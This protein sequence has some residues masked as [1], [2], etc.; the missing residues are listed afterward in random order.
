MWD[1]PRAPRGL[2]RAGR[3][4]PPCSPHPP[5]PVPTSGLFACPP[6]G[7]APA[8]LSVCDNRA[9]NPA[10]SANYSNQHRGKGGGGGSGTH[11]GLYPVSEVPIMPLHST[12]PLQVERACGEAGGRQ[13]EPEHF[14]VTLAVTEGG[15][16]GHP[17]SRRPRSPL[18]P[19]QGSSSLLSLRIRTRWLLSSCLCLPSS[20]AWLRGPR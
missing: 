7:F 1:R 8:G 16:W 15:G 2:Q 20:A 11:P 9:P 17:T 19:P 14:P 12:L 10:I 3:P 18:P 5:H 13:P 6:W 4:S